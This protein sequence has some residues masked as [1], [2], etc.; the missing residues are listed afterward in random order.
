MGYGIVFALIRFDLTGSIH[1]R[2]FHNDLLI[3]GNYTVTHSMQH[4]HWF[5]LQSLIQ[6]CRN[7]KYLGPFFTILFFCTAALAAH[8]SDHPLSPDDWKEVM[9][10]VVL[11]E[12]AGFMP[13]LLPVIMRN[14]DTLELSE[15]QL[16]LFRAWRRKNYTNMVNIMN[17]IIG[18]M[19]EFRVESLSPQITSDQLL[20]FQSEIQGL[21][22]QLLKIKLSCRENIL[23]TFTDKQWENFAFVIADD[24]KLASLASQVGSLDLEH[25]Q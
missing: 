13:T 3:K 7:M 5:I 21:Q 9:D 25:I 14:Q 12:D 23:T 11:L 2:V 4:I 19:V 24:P 17:E 20:A 15:E 10:K 18:K 1:I 8:N 22:R 16:G 6:G